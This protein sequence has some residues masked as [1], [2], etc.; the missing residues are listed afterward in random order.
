M[1]ACRVTWKRVMTT[2]PQVR[3]DAETAIARLKEQAAKAGN[4]ATEVQQAV[5][6][7]QDYFAKVTQG[8]TQHQS[9][10]FVR[11]NKEIRCDITSGPPIKLGS[12]SQEIIARYIDYYDGTNVVTMAAVG[13]DMPKRG[14]L[15]R[16]KKDRLSHCAPGFSDIEFLVGA[17]I[18]EE[19]SP[20]NSSLK[21]KGDSVVLEKQ[22]KGNRNY[23]MRLTLSKEHLRPVEFEAIDISHTPEDIVRLHRKA[24]DYKHYGDQVWFPSKITT[25]RGFGG[26]EDVLVSAVFN[27][28]VDPLELR[29]PVSASIADM[30]FGDRQTVGYKLQN[31]KLLT[32]DEVKAL[33]G[34][35]QE[36]EKEQKKSAPS[37][38]NDTGPVKPSSVIPRSN[39]SFPFPY[40]MGLLLA[41]LS[42]MV[43]VRRHN[44]E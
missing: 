39:S 36:A 43:W 2:K 31:G 17:P 40:H 14:Q 23:L 15:S 16:D 25:D 10:S 35:K 11:L 8:S 20:Q 30:R 29:L 41:A 5:K 9:L 22:L 3:P 34:K 37:L 1:M 33:L 6:N 32:D 7:A 24:S 13:K 26:E 19:F 44:S 27:A 4:N 21:E 18:T 42:C 38:S 28:V 12:V